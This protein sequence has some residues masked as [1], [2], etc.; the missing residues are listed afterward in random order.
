MAKVY[1]SIMNYHTSTRTRQIESSYILEATSKPSSG[2]IPFS[3]YSRNLQGTTLLNRPCKLLFTFSSTLFCIW[4][5]HRGVQ[6]LM[7]TEYFTIIPQNTH[8]PWKPLSIPPCCHP[9]NGKSIFI[10]VS[11]PVKNISYNGTIAQGLLWQTFR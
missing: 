10:S 7:N 2:E 1:I 4:N 11:Y 9:G 8:S 3:P 5:I 6:T